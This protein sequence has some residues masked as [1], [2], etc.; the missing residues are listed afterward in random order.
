M[1][2][3]RFKQVDVFTAT[4]LAG[5]PVAVVLDAEGIDDATM[6]R[7]AAWTNLSET[8]FVLPP[9]TAA[10]DYRLRIF[11]PR[12]EL[13]FA[14]HPTLGSAHAVVE[15]GVVAPR[16]GVVRQECGAGILPIRV[17]GA[18]FA[19]R[20]PEAKVVRE[21]SVDDAA[22][23]G[24]L[25]RAIAGTPL[26]IDVGPVWLV[27]EID[28]EA[29]LRG[30]APDMVAIERLSRPRGLTGVTLFALPARPGDPVVVRSFAPAAGVPEDPVCGTGSAA[31]GAHLGVSGR[32]TETGHAFRTS[33]GREVG[34]DGTVGVTV[35]D[36]GRTVEIAG[37]SVTVIDGHVAGLETR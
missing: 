4:P 1:A 27:A 29:T 9:T 19:V 25:G 34:R 18:R 31:V 16:G 37:T 20:V 2:E 7:F 5:N 23:A 8:T 3:R 12:S 22:L 13:P 30:L 28:D 32:T 26:A 10:A 17:D 35:T 33:Q 24:A 36:G 14:G 15:A 6:Q 11:H 21:A